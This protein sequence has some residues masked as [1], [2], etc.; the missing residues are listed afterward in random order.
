MNRASGVGLG[1]GGGEAKA[2]G[3]G[4]GIAFSEELVDTVDG[5]SQDD[6]S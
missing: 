2:S 5:A 1:G 6:I 3:G 4:V